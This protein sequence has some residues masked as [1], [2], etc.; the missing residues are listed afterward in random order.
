MD[1]IIRIDLLIKQMTTKKLIWRTMLIKI[2][3]CKHEG[4]RIIFCSQLTSVLK[5]TD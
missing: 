2:L 1:I 3:N 5:L 4:I